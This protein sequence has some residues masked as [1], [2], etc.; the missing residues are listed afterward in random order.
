MI[1]LLNW[2]M[3]QKRNKIILTIRIAK[4]VVYYFAE[5]GFRV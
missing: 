3:N 1:P 2:D 5:S 4:N